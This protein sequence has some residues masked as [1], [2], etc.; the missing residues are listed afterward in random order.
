MVPV[1]ALQLTVKREGGAHAAAVARKE[2]DVL[3]VLAVLEGIGAAAGAHKLFGA[4]VDG[5]P[6]EP[7]SR[8]DLDRFAG[9]ALV[10]G[11]QLALLLAGGDG[12]QACQRCIT[13]IDPLPPLFL[14]GEVGQQPAALNRC[15]VGTLVA[16]LRAVGR[17]K[18]VADRQPAVLQAII[19]PAGLY[20]LFS[21]F[22]VGS[23]GK[24]AIHKEEHL[25]CPAA[26]PLPGTIEGIG[27]TCEPEGHHSE[28]GREDEEDNKGLFHDEG[29]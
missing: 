11:L 5:G 1:A 6:L 7:R 18:L 9:A 13:V 26:F 21:P 19:S 4:R 8:Q 24:V 23:M 17:I 12:P 22:I 14:T 3:G 20:K 16:H 15:G 2:F 28:E 25:F 27:S 29:V 10:D